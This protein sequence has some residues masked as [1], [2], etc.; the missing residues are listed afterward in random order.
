M[1]LGLE[2]IN[3]RLDKLREEVA[4]LKGT[5]QRLSLEE[6]ISVPEHYKSV[7]RTFQIAIECCHDIATHII[8]AF[9]MKRPDRYESAFE[10]LGEFGVLPLDFACVLVGMARF[11]NLL[12]HEYLKVKL[13]IVYEKLQNN[14]SDFDKFAKYVVEFLEKEKR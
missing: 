7:E 10:I 5:A 9:D 11:R 14:L 8:S 1:D 6:F 13:N 12:T 3:E 4:F 2:S